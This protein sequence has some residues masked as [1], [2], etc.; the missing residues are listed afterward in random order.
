MAV[1]QFIHQ[2]TGLHVVLQSDVTGGFFAIVPAL[3]GC[4]SQG[5]SVVETLD[6][7][8]DAL[9]AVLDVMCEDDPLGEVLFGTR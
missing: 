3:P 9:M 1:K 4:G 2:L 7:V 5:E 6:N 8:D